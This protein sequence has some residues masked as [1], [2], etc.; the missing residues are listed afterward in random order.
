[1]DRLKLIAFDEQDLGII[2]AHIQDAVLKIGDLHFD[3]AGNRF[4]IELNRFVWEKAVSAKVTQNYERRK[5]ILHFERVNKVQSLSLN[6][7]QH[8]AV[9]ALLTIRYKNK[10]DDDQGPEGVI[11]IIF[12]GGATIQ[13]FV[14]CIEA[15]LTDLAGSW[16]TASLPNHDDDKD[17]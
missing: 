2:A 15:Q 9:L 12:A 16:E 17:A 11:E 5:T 8:D 7:K 3:T 6:Q 14:E 10:S 4:V 13:L 1:M